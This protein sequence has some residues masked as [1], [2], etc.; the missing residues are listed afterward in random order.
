MHENTLAY[1][2]T[3]LQGS[4][5]VP[6]DRHPQMINIPHRKGNMRDSV[7]SKRALDGPNTAQ[8]NCLTNFS[9]I[10]QASLRRERKRYQKS[11]RK[12][13]TL[14]EMIRLGTGSS[15]VHTQAGEV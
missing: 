6:Q 7:T 9:P 10:E 2:N 12:P 5:I 3:K 14:Y 11:S 13:F 4:K 1:I 8:S 15:W